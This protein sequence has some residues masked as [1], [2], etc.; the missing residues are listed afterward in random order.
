MVG[1]LTSIP[2]EMSQT[3]ASPPM[4]LATELNSRNLTGS[5]RALSFTAISAAA[6]TDSG[7]R[8]NGANAQAD[9]SVNGRGDLDTYRY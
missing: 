8:T 1:W 9:A 6:S 4:W 3:H 5:A 2:A 7:S